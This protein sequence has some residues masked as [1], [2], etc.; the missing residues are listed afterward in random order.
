MVKI[1]IPGFLN[2]ITKTKLVEIDIGLEEVSV[3]QVIELLT[4]RYGLEF[5]SKI[6]EDGKPKRFI[7]IY[8]NGEDIRFLNGLETKLGNSSELSI[9]PAVSGG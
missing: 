9:L 7:N 2:P 3:K 6:L 4:Q 5:E 8:L 1:R